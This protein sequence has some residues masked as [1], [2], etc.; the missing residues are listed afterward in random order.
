MA[1]PKRD[2]MAPEPPANLDKIVSRLVDVRLVELGILSPRRCAAC[3]YW[4]PIGSY[5]FHFDDAVPAEVQA[6]GCESWTQGVLV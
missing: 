1:K 5:C 3:E 6:K 2:Y 4:C